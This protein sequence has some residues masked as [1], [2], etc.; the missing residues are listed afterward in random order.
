MYVQR[1]PECGQ[2]LNTNYCDI[3]MKKVPFGG[4][5]LANRRDPWENRDGSSAHRMEKDHECISFEKPEKKSFRNPA[6]KQTTASKKKAAPVLGIILAILSLLP[7]LFGLF[8]E[9]ADS[10]AV[11]E[12]EYNIHDGFVE[13]GDP[14]AEGVPNVIA[15]EIYNANG[16]RVTADT[17]GLSYG[18]Y[19]VFITIENETEQ[20]IS[21][22]FTMV[23]INDYMVPFGVYHDLKP[24]ESNQIS[25]S[26]YRHE[27][28]KSGISQVSDLTF[29]MDVYEADTYE[30]I[31]TGELLTIKTEYD[32][33]AEPAVDTSGLELYNDGS[34]CVILRDVMLDDY[35]DCELD[36]YMENLSDS[37]VNVYSGQV[38]AN[39]EEVS[40][41]I[42]RELRTNTRVADRVYL[43]ELDE[44]V[45]LDIEDLSQI[46]EITID[47]YVDY[48]DGWDI[49]ESISESVTFDPNAI[50]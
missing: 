49:V 6:K 1:C 35:G 42:S 20:K 12:P 50:P 33:S 29:V 11:P 32:G 45:D 36:L 44:R 22:S 30:E 19:T 40:G 18:V 28:E 39:G 16:I 7:A 5:K 43:Y 41:Y 24:G 2:R 46:Q 25:W 47:L 23:S 27:L 17:A 21:V 3:C 4:V 48:M 13:A 26:F 15:G 10:V 34:F 31:V 37:T 38:W 9:A 8:E 14:G